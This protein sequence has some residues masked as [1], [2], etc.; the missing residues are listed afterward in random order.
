MDLK[1]RWT[2]FA[3]MLL[4]AWLIL[5]PVT[6]GGTNGALLRSDIVSGLLLIAFACCFRKW[7][8][9][10]ASLVGV[11][12]LL[13]PLVFWAPTAVVYCNDTLAGILA[14]AFSVV[15]PREEAI[16]PEI[17]PGWSYNPSSFK[18]R[19]PIAILAALGSFS[20]RYM[21]SFQ[22]GYIDQMWDPIFPEGTLRVITS[23]ISRSFPV[24]DAGLGCVAYVIEALMAC[25]GGTR[26]WRTMP[27]FVIL[28]GIVV[29]PLGLV[30]IT[31][32][33]LQPTVV[34]AWCTWCLFAAVCMLIMIALAAD[35]VVAVL[36]HLAR[37]KRAGK[38][39]WLTLWRG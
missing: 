38:P 26:R 10:C 18:A 24:S 22:L 19:L 23:D 16:G 17:P 34:G 31:L 39:F 15:I 12:L 35:E 30:S 7:A 32:V 1:N 37:C 2:P 3:L 13:A 28:F 14:I 29:I 36:Q 33:I 8:D 20:A 25:K 5:S 21:A 6:F 27:W 9:W 4:G 11:W